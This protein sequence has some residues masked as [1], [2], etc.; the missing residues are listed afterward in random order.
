MADN[1][2]RNLFNKARARADNGKERD[3]M[4]PEDDNPD[5]KNA[6][7]KAGKS[8]ANAAKSIGKAVL[9]VGKAIVQFL[10]KLG[11]PGWIALAIII[12][13]III[14]TLSTAWN[15][16]PRHDEV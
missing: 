16:M 10:I 1:D 2:F 7:K 12:L 8:A 3:I 15:M 9:K 5:L 13:L 14:S 6:S 11:P 4:N